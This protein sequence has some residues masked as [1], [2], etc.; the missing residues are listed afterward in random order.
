M[1]RMKWLRNILDNIIYNLSYKDLYKYYNN[2]QVK[3]NIIYTHTKYTH[4]LSPIK[5]HT[6]NI[7]LEKFV[8]KQ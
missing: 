4:Y 3:D 7:Y 6:K 2:E 1:H 8:L 5:C